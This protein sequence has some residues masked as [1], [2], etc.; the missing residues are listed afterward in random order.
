V[1]GSANR[2]ESRFSSPERL[3][4]HRKPNLH[5]AF[6][7]VGITAWAPWLAW[8]AKSQSRPYLTIL[9]CA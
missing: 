5:I 3:D 2:D 9:D 4:I 8:K 1:L 6:G 7:K